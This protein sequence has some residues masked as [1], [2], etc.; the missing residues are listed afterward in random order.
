MACQAHAHGDKV[1]V[2]PAATWHFC[3]GL[4][5]VTRFAEILVDCMR[6]K[7]LRLLC[8]YDGQSDDSSSPIV[9]IS[10]VP[11]QARYHF[12]PVRLGG[13]MESHLPK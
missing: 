11:V 3:Y 7:C 2:H 8:W 12:R 9:L 4:S 10:I 1:T 6:A 5:A 13:S